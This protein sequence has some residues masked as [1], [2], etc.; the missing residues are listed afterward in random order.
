MLFQQVD[1]GESMNWF[2]KEK[3]NQSWK[4][5]LSIRKLQAL[6]IADYQA[7]LFA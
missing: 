4:R 1:G 7:P 3:R 6:S 5:S 2:T